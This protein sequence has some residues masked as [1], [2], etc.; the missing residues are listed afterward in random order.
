[1][2]SLSTWFNTFLG[3]ESGMKTITVIGSGG[4]TSLIWHLASCLGSSTGESGEKTDLKKRKI[5]V[6][7]TTK[8]FM[9]DNNFIRSLH[10]VTFEG[11][12]NKTSGKIESLPPGRLEDL[13]PD[14]DLVLI[15]GDGSRGLPLKA[16]ED[17]EPVVPSFTDLTI[18][19]LP[20]WPMGKP[21]S[22]EIVHRL[23]LFCALTGARVGEPLQMEHILA[24]IPGLFAKARGKKIL[25][26]NQI[27][28]N[29]S[30][31]LARQ[32]TQSLP[33]T[34]LRMPPDFRAGLCKIIAGSVFSNYLEVLL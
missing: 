18:G 24:L 27:E 17:K 13:I 10:G 4:K 21:V 31:E 34:G 16:W 5:L 9:P 11:T 14:Y 29:A 28:D 15:E 2:Q 22:E 3:I 23:P 33:P 7:T 20:L 6:T 30:L 25:F 8:M 1:M 12:F 32:L 19:M 26:F